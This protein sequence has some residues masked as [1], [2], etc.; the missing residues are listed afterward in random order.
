MVSKDDVLAALAEE[1]LK[2][3][4]DAPPLDRSARPAAGCIDCRAMLED[5]C[6]HCRPLSAQAEDMRRMSEDRTWDPE[7]RTII[8]DPCYVRLVIFTPS[9]QGLTAELPAAL[10]FYREQQEYIRGVGDD[11]LAE[12]LRHARVN[13][14]MSGMPAAYRASARACVAMAEREQERRRG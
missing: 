10:R 5:D 3:P 9:Q 6:L 4:M 13:A 14:E 2:Q 8:C 7:T 11:T 1:V 12:E